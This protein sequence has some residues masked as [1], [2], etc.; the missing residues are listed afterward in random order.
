MIQPKYYFHNVRLLS[1]VPLILYFPSVH[2]S[3]RPFLTVILS[4]DMS[5]SLRAVE[6]SSINTSELGLA[7]YFSLLHSIVTW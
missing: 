7:C 2:H 3:F 1:R 5:A 4:L 6:R